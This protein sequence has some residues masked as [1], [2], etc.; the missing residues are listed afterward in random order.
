[1]W[2]KMKTQDYKECLNAVPLERKISY[3]EKKIKIGVDQV[4][5][6]QKDFLIKNYFE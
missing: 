2:H 4:K 1:M 6:H 3:L 5:R